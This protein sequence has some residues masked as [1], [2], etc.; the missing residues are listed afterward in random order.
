[1]RVITVEN[2]KQMRAFTDLPKKLMRGVAHFVPPMWM[3]EKSAYTGKNNPILKNSEFVLLLL[4]GEQGKPI[5]RCIAYIDFNHNQFYGEKT[6]FF[7]AFLC[8]DDKRAG[9]MLVSAAEEWLTAKGMERIRGPINPAAEEWGFVFE[10][11]DSDP[12][13]M[14]PWNPPYYHDFFTQTGYGKV[15]DLLV[16]EA[17]MQKGYRLPDR[18]ADFIVRYQKRCP[19]IQ[20]RRLNLKK[21]KADA[22]AIWEI[23]NIALADNWGYVPLELPVMED[24]L[25]K[26]R[27]IVDPD[28]VWIVEDS[29]RPVGFCLGFPDINIILKA[30]GGK[31][32]PLGWIKL[33]GAKKLRDYRLFGL[34]VHPDW[35]GKALDALMYINLYQ[36]L[37]Y[38]NIRMEANYILEDNNHIK[39]ALEKLGMKKI[40]IYRIY[41]KTLQSA[42]AKA[43]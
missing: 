1:M 23:S 3:D 42:G 6:G 8:I 13:Y 26:L 16:Y 15:K 11:Y 39:N 20:I 7:G 43:N 35:H 25:K 36:H 19:N 27:L 17:D 12:V 4:L 9:T 18:Y 24:M 34:A 5:G 41:E 32:L 33:L 30:I 31:L 29:G 10:G 40:K 22:K 37:K 2:K 21:I 38:K 28:A 14:S